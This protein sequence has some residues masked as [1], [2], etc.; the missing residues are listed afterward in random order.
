MNRKIQISSLFFCLV[1]SANLLCFQDELE[2]TAPYND[3][4]YS[5]HT[6]NFDEL[7]KR[8]QLEQEWRSLDRQFAEPIVRNPQYKD[9]RARRDFV[10]ANRTQHTIVSQKSAFSAP[11]AVATPVQLP[12]A[13]HV[14]FKIWR[15]NSNP[16]VY[17]ERARQQL[18]S[19]GKK[20]NQ[21]NEWWPIMKFDASGQKIVNMAACCNHA[22]ACKNFECICK[23]GP[24]KIHGIQVKSVEHARLIVA[25][26]KRAKSQQNV[27]H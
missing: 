17:R 6:Q 12:S 1:I 9:P 18:E 26:Y 14:F 21:E 4:G 10:Q 19:V 24:R 15:N 11:C 8:R 25:E 5:I 7:I 22:T 16:L 23:G 3:E 27:P 2:A 13:E 20:K